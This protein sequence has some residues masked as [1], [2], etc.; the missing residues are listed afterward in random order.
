MGRRENFSNVIILLKFYLNFTS[1]PNVTFQKSDI[2]TVDQVKLG[3]KTLETLERLGAIF[4]IHIK[5]GIVAWC[6]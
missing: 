2:K 6:L 1:E 4:Y 3:T 5:S